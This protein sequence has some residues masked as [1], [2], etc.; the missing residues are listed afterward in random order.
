MQCKTK[1]LTNQI[2]IFVISIIS[3]AVYTNYLHQDL[4]SSVGVL[5]KVDDLNRGQ[6][7]SS[8]FHSYYT[9]M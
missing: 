5:S 6:P 9:E 2:N 1:Q 3:L 4:L 8:L 7:E